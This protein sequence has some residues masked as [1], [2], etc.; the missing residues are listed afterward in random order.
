MSEQIVYSVRNNMECI[1]KIIDIVKMFDIK[2]PMFV[3]GK[4]FVKEMIETLNS[5]GLDMV[6]FNDFTPNPVYEDVSKGVDL[7]RSQDC[8]F[9]ISLGGG[10]VIDTAKNIVLFSSLDSSKNYLDQDYTD[11]E[12][13]HLSI[14][15]T[16]GTGS[17]AT[18]FSVL[19]YRGEKKSVAY[20]NMAPDYVI[21]DPEFLINLPVY[22]KK[23]TMLDALCQAIESYWSVNSTEESK[24][25][26]KS[27]IEEIMDNYSAYIDAPET[28][29]CI[30]IL[31]ASNLAGKA[32]NISK[33]T[34]AH[35]M[36]YKITSLYGFSHGHAAALCLPKV[37]RFMIHN[38]N[39]CIDPRGKDYLESIFSHIDSIFNTKSHD[40]S[41]DKFERLFNSMNL[42]YP[43]YRNEEELVLL[44]ESVNVQRLQNNPIELSVEEIKD[45]YREILI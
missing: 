14:P 17:E 41:V 25:Y 40:E 34:A 20:K 3:C 31:N 18:S 27:A 28:E 21:F 6:V 15:T 38:M 10:S 8:D 7:F 13:K 12:I 30:K 35:A 43:K 36:C 26:A 29:V 16:A 24:G 33:T 9:M 5:K 42:E 39:K 11:T 32:I 1:D 23:A 22:Q 44:S 4:S 45:I 2:K 37:W 19:Y